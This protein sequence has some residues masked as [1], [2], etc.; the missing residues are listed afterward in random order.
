VKKI[1][2]RSDD[3]KQQDVVR[4][5]TKELEN[6]REATQLKQKHIVQFITAFRR[7]DAG[8][9]AC[10][11]LCEWADGG[12]LREFWFSSNSR[13]K[14][15]ASLVLEAT[16][17]LHGLSEALCAAHYPDSKK[18]QKH[19][20]RH[21]DLKP[22]NI[23]RFKGKGLIGTLKIGD[24]GLARLKKDVTQAQMQRSSNPFGTV[25]YEAPEA[26]IGVDTKRGR[27]QMVRSRLYDVW[28]MGCITLEFVIW[29]L[30]G[31]D[32]LSKFQRALTSQQDN[33]PFYERRQVLNNVEV[34]LHSAV[35]DAMRRIEENPAC[36]EGTALRHLLELARDRLLVIRLPK[37]LGMRKEDEE[38][39]SEENEERKNTLVRGTSDDEYHDENHNEG[40]DE[41]QETRQSPEY[42]AVPAKLATP[43]IRTQ[44]VPDSAAG[45]SFRL[46]SHDIVEDAAVEVTEPQETEEPEE[47]EDHAPCRARASELCDE[48]E[49]ILGR[50]NDAGY[51]LTHE[52]SEIMNTTLRGQTTQQV[53][54]SS[55]SSSYPRISSG[56]STFVDSTYGTGATSIPS[57]DEVGQSD[58]LGVAKQQEV[59]V[60][61]EVQLHNS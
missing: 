32:G 3:K 46:T 11:L 26:R 19:M 1:V 36:G 13:P 10:Y 33:S 54:S 30:E 53:S 38:Q 9:M 15:T 22:D 41:L 45:I 48:L 23:L 61:R 31:S 58:F 17:Q 18:K 49:K 35:I 24:W 14:L 6:L 29:L 42:L 5:W 37:N 57:G 40:Y 50:R 59:S 21:G 55:S 51:W 4:N 47:E 25:Q 43:G 56:G 28:A 12:N 2:P 8:T 60:S 34:R 39:A 27:N 16:T 7:E 44:H 20:I 52:S